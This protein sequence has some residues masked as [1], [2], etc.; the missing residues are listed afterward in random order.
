MKY[1]CLLICLAFCNCIK[2]Q[3]ADDSV[4]SAVNQLFTAMKNADSALLA[5]SFADSA[6][7]QTIVDKNGKVEVKTEAIADFASQVGKMEKNI[8]DE[9][10]QFDVIKIDGALAIVW[11]PYQF[12]YKGKF[13]HC[14]A[15]SFQ[16][17]RINGKWK[18]QYLIDTRRR[19]GC[20]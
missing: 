14:G 10:I 12:Y 6:I 1:F 11:A 20:Q 2:A 8:L 16:L 15:D 7:L 19:D 13:S 5:S 4:R 9:R 18:I 3:S 17:I